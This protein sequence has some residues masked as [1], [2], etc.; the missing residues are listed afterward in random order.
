MKL[1]NLFKNYKTTS[2]GLLSIIGG[3]T[4]LGFGLA[5]DQVTEEVVMTAAT[6]ILLG[7]GLL[8]AR[9]VNVTSTDLGLQ[10]IEKKA[11]AT[12]VVTPTAAK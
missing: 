5:N 6:T 11:D 8:F 2:A 12:K 7:I 10:S 3:L 9:D 4:R 1:E